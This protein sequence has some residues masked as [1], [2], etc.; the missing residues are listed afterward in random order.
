MPKYNVLHRANPPA[1]FVKGEL[2]AGLCLRGF[3][4]FSMFIFQIEKPL[5]DAGGVG[6]VD[7]AFAV[8][9]FPYK[10][11]TLTFFYKV[12]CHLFLINTK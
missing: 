7:D 8:L 11:F 9:R 10:F 5:N 2:T 1:P 6:F 3:I 12:I 4:D